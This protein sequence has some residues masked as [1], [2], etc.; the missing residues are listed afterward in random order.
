[1]VLTRLITSAISFFELNTP[2]GLLG[3]REKGVL[4]NAFRSIDAAKLGTVS[5]G[6]FIKAWSLLS[7]SVTSE[8]ATGLF[9]KY[10]H[11][12]QGRMPYEVSVQFA[13]DYSHVASKVRVH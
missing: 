10:G 7:V 9:L 1:M 11:D 13:A 12:K 5:P 4:L 6:G 8:E 2:R 3:L